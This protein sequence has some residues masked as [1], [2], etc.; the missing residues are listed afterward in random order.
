[1]FDPPLDAAE[2][3][4]AFPP[5]RFGTVSHL[6]QGGQGVVFLTEPINGHPNAQPG[7]RTALKVFVPGS[8]RERQE[9]EVLALKALSCGSLSRFIDHGEIRIRGD[10]CLFLETE[11]IEGPTLAERL[12]TRPLTVPEVARLV[13]DLAI[14]IDAMWDLGVVH[15][16]IK[17]ANIILRANGHPVL[18]DLGMARH[19]DRSSI[20]AV[21]NTLGTVGYLSPEQTRGIRQLSCKSDVYALGVT[22][23]QALLGRHPLAH[24][25]QRMVRVGLARTVTLAPNAPPEFCQS[26]DSMVQREP[27]PRPMPLAVVGDMEPF[28]PADDDDEED[29]DSEE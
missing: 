26:I 9:R 24:D 16:D 29:E 20:T 18:I 6:S 4:S 15:R 12:V 27:V 8:Q 13:H 17:P 1:M 22:A 3:L 28:L 19:T 25:Q 5:D 21:G 7:D 2:I 10:D 14:A 23:Q 11:F